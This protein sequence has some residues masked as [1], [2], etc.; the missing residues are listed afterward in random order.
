MESGFGLPPEI[1]ASLQPVG[2][3]YVPENATQ[4]ASEHVGDGCAAE[5][6][7]PRVYDGYWREVWE[8]TKY[9]ERE[10][11]E[12]PIRE[13]RRRVFDAGMEGA[14]ITYGFGHLNLAAFEAFEKNF[15]QAGRVE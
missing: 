11:I 10:A 2:S 1:L 12:R 5:C 4:R 7:Q 3:G 15:E 13:Q 9:Q 8:E 14:G 6:C